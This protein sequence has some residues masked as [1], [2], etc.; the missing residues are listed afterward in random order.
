MDLTRAVT[1]R[2]FALN[3][4][5]I[6]PV[7]GMLH[8]VT[9]CTIDSADINDVDVV[10]FTEKRSLQDGL[11]AGDVFLGGRRIRLSG[12]LYAITRPLL[13]DALQ[14]LRAALSPTLAFRSEPGAKGYQPLYYSVPT[15]RISD[16]PSGAIPLRILAMPH[17]F[18]AIIQRDSIGGDDLDSLAIPWQATLTCVNPAIMGEAPQDYA[19]TTGGTH[20]DSGTL[21][22]R[23]DYHAPLHMLIGVN[24]ASGS[25]VVSA[26]GANFTITL[27]A[28][29]GARVIRY[30]G[31]DKYLT[32]EENNIEALRMSLL[33]FQ[34]ATTHPLVPG[35]ESAYSVAFTGVTVAADSHMWFWEQYA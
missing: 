25:I 23:G 4:P 30:N 14:E 35:G 15:N 26:G 6:S 3:T 11:D 1:Y 7:D 12:T 32:V 16:Y 5:Q 29:T 18:Q 20:T 2:G 33:T 31:T 27:P 24:N 19:F 34:N 8:G 13:F 21:V 22:N 17:S 28:S 10:Q 9:G